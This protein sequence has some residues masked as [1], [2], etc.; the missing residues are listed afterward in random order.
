MGKKS[1]TTSTS[2]KKSTTAKTETVK[3]AAPSKKK[4]ALKKSAA[5]KSTKQVKAKASAPK[6]APKKKSPAKSSKPTLQEILFKKFDR[7]IPETIYSPP[8]EKDS[9]R[10]F[11]S[12]PLIS[13]ADPKDV[14]RIRKLLFTKFDM[15]MLKAATEK[16]AAEKAAAEKAAAEKAATEKAAAEKAAAEKA[17]AE[18][19][20]AEKAAVEKAAV[21]KAPTEE[22]VVSY[23]EPAK[24]RPFMESLDTE[25]MIL[26]GVVAGIAFLFILIIGA[27][28]SNMS[29]YYIKPAESGIEIWRGKF[30]P[31][32]ERPMIV[33]PSVVAPETMKA[34]YGQKDVY[35]I[36]FKFYLDKADALIESPGLPDFEGIKE[37][38]Y[39]AL[40]YGI[41]QELK[42]TA[43]TRI[44]G[45]D[46]MT[47]LYKAD[48]AA[49]KNTV[50]DLENAMEH[51]SKASSL[52]PDAGQVELITQK[53]T[54]FKAMKNKLREAEKKAK[55]DAANAKKT[56]KE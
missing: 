16:A 51:L 31:L 30:A 11:A 13:A 3:K 42:E 55:A 5:S 33:L 53:Q 36:V 10:I 6:R 9:L 43:Y 41:S 28:L 38:L 21:E 4:A 2:K 26:A 37:H 23:S 50:S 12:P 47:L 15:E 34:R 1:L 35:P 46:R 56:V 7:H 8:A 17:A 39:T 52:N 18:K 29:N 27:S 24:K 25:K 19:A 44:D 32:G 40:E 48:V 54:Q 45:I 49:S 20:A 14:E 22:V